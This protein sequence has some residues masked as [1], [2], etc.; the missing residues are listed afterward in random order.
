[1]ILRCRPKTRD[2]SN[3]RVPSSTLQASCATSIVSIATEEFKTSLAFWPVL[4][5]AVSL[6]TSVAY[7]S[8]RDSSIPYRRKR[9]YLLFHSSCDIL[10]GLSEVFPSARAMARLAQ[11]TLREMERVMGKHR[12]TQ[13][14]ARNNPT[15]D[16]EEASRTASRD[17][18]MGISG[19]ATPFMPYLRRQVDEVPVP[20]LLTENNAVRPSTPNAAVFYLDSELFTDFMGDAGIFNDFDPSFDLDRIDAA[21]SA[22]LDPSLPVLPGEWTGGQP[23]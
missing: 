22:N 21:F 18:H 11:D 5:Y 9:A 16:S 10:D 13:G 15:N 17:M 1:M 7:K 4:P 23:G 6:A 8:L 19:P 2:G 12:T 20:Q 3:E 14:G